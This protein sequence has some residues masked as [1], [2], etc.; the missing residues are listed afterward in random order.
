MGGLGRQGVGGGQEVREIGLQ[1]VSSSSEVTQFLTS[2]QPWCGELGTKEE[3]GWGGLYVGEGSYGRL[4]ELE[5]ERQKSKVVKRGRGREV[6]MG[7]E[8]H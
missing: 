2:V 5:E 1:E 7:I 3:K 4:L 8:R 6:M